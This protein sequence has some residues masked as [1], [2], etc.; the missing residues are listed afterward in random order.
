MV[1]QLVWN[2]QFAPDH[3]YLRCLSPVFI[4]P[5]GN[6]LEP[7]SH[8]G[9]GEE[10]KEDRNHE[11]HE[12]HEKENPRRE[13]RKRRSAPYSSLFLSCISCLSWSISSSL[14]RDLRVSVVMLPSFN[15]FVL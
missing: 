15:E 14:L 10:E 2:N 4:L 7:R 8:G 3:Y 9:H 12:I 5:Q 11:K 13:V 6:G 1:F